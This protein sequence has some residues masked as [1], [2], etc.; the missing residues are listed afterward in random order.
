MKATEDAKITVCEEYRQ[1]ESSPPI[2]GTVKTACRLQASKTKE[3]LKV[4]E[5]YK[6]TQ[7]YV[8]I[9]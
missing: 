7:N 3:S 8:G 6:E 1:I 2:A 4:K 5:D 9:S